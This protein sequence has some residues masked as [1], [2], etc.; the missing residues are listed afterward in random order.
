MATTKKPKAA[1]LKSDLALM[2]DIAISQHKR[3]EAARKRSLLISCC[4]RLRA[5]IACTQNLILKDEYKDVLS[6]D[7]RAALHHWLDKADRDL[8]PVET[9]A[10]PAELAQ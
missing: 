8:A 7:D 4:L 2:T 10:V 6:D 9:L 1:E 3:A 5:E